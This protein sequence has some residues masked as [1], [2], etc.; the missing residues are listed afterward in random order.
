VRS[1]LVPLRRDASDREGSPLERALRRHVDG[2]VRF[3]RGTRALYTSDASNYRHSPIGV[4]VP[5]TLDAVVSAVAICR[6][7][8][9]PVLPRGGGTSLAGQSCNEAVVIDCSR[10]LRK[11]DVDGEHGIARVEPG[12]VLDD[13]RHAAAPYD[14]DF[15]PDPSTHDRCTLGGMLGN[16]SCGVHSVM[17]EFHGAGPRTSDHVESLDI[18]TY[19]GQRMRVGRGDAATDIHR[20]LRN[21]RDRYADLIRSGFPHMPRLVS[22]FNLPALLEENGFD[23]AR[24]L[25]GTEATCVLVLGATVKLDPAKPARAAALL[26]FPDIAAAD[27]V[28]A[29]RELRPV[30]CEAID[31]KLAARV[32]R[33]GA[34]PDVLK[35][36]LAGGAWLIVEHGGATMAEVR[37]L[38]SATIHRLGRRGHS[39]LLDDPSAF[40]V[41]ADI[42]EAA[43]G[44]TAMARGQPDTYEGWEDAAV[45]PDRLG[46]YLREFER[47]LEAH[48]LHGALYGHFGQGCVHTRLDFALG[49]E[50]GVERYRRFT[51]DAA[52]LVASFGGSLSGEHG[53]GQSRGDLLEV[54]FGRDLVAA[55]EDYKEI[56]DPDH[57]MN[58]GKVVW[59]RPRTSDLRLTDY[60]P[61]PGPIELS[62]GDDEHDFGHAAVRCVGIGKCR[63]TDHGTMCPSYMVTRDERHSTR[64]RAHLL[65][66]MMRGDLITDGWASREVSEA[67]DLCLSCK[68]CK[69]ECPMGVDMAAYKAE[70]LA[71][72]HE[73]V[74]RP[75]QAWMFGKIHRWLQL[76]RP[77]APIVNLLAATPGLSWV[78][79]RALGI[80]TDRSLPRLHRRTFR[81]R[82]R[83]RPLDH[84]ARRV[85]LWVDTFNNNFHP[86]ILEAAVDVLRATNH[87]VVIP[88]VDLCCARPL[89]EHGWIDQARQ[90]WHQNLDVL[91]AEIAAGTP[92]VGLEPSCTAMFRD[93]L[94]ALLP[95]IYDAQRLAAQTITIG[96]LLEEDGWQPPP[97]A[98]TALFHRHCHQAAL[99]APEH[100]ITL[101]SASGLDVHVLD[102]G[103]CGMA[104]PFGFAKKTHDVS[105]ARAERVLLPA[106][107]GVGD[108]TVVITDG[109]SCRE[110]LRQLGDVRAL[111]TVEVLR[112]A[113]RG[114]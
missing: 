47:L 54:Q 31:D 58:P 105:V 15:G 22:G 34:I 44:A 100:E 45:P 55:F 114:D 16:D 36:I 23:V 97:L 110:Q 101:L 38:A 108:E 24:S 68:A 92:I 19:R 73:T 14:W 99:L 94:V 21:L 67:L 63:K 50:A 61:D 30:G 35:P 60:R 91:A 13:L 90:Q 12:V 46:A 85:L 80:A 79:K 69:H 52:A 65:F 84:G 3:D 64:G 39:H 1:E 43:L 37:E 9:V 104:G 107:R 87:D 102:S 27:L 83:R 88:H 70:F 4:V 42:R 106:V 77:F 82:F 72:H 25:V 81:R 98:G 103:C 66:E 78:G 76:G 74:R 109:F 59:P 6:E 48:R 96:E 75:I 28:P 18:L 20:A 8:G 2:E 93:E 89:F 51:A 49:T 26:E 40:A 71:H 57:K 33:S 111:H 95:D 86:E 41:L 62:F 11:V 5:R 53:D 113:L 32:H 29:V 56:W 10:H 7:H 17:S 112:A